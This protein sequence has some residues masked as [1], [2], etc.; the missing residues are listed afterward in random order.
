MA[1][2]PTIVNVR[3]RLLTLKPATWSTLW[4]PVRSALTLIS[5]ACSAPAWP[6]TAKPPDTPEVRA[7]ASW[8]EVWPANCSSTR[9]SAWEPEVTFQEP[10]SPDVEAAAEAVGDGRARA[11]GAV[12][13]PEK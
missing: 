9:Y 2:T 6:L 8:L 7:T 3:S 5:L 11:A 13:S 4:R 1:F 10:A 12:R